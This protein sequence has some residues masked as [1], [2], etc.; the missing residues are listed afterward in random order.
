MPTG[1]GSRVANVCLEV[2]MSNLWRQKKCH[3]SQN[4]VKKNLTLVSFFC[5]KHVRFAFFWVAEKLCLLWISSWQLRRV[6]RAARTEQGCQIDQEVYIDAPNGRRRTSTCE[7]SLEVKSKVNSNNF[8]S[9]FSQLS[10]TYFLTWKLVISR[11]VLEANL[12]N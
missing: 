1:I 5:Q 2:N 12:A 6:V 10:S 11:Q 8:G 7:T 4:F 9:L 3:E